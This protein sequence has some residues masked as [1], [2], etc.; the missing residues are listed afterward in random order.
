M[1][2]DLAQSGGFALLAVLILIAVLYVGSAGIFIAARAELA[3]ASN[4]AL[5][6]RTFHA[7]EGALASWLAETGHMADAE[8]VVGGIT[9]T[10]EAR[11][12]LAVDSTTALFAVSAWAQPG[13]GASAGSRAARQVSIVAVRTLPDAF[14]SVPGTWR[15]RF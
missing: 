4:L 8:Y 10:I 15:E 2:D 6:E 11:P 5:A 13:A 7:A 1:H 14:T 3:A 12:L 9:V